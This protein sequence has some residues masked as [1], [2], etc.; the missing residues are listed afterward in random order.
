MKIFRLWGII[1][2]F[3]LGG[4]LAASW[5]FLAPNLIKNTIE[6]V[7]S[8]SLGAKVDIDKVEVALFPLRI[9]IARLQ[10]T[11]PDQP[12]SN[13]F[14]AEKINFALDTNALL[15]KK[16]LIE[17]LT[18]TGVQVGTKRTSSGEL[19]NGRKTEVVAEQ[20]AAIELP[21]LTESDIK[22]MVEQADL[23][24]VKRLQVLD[25]SQK[26]IQSE[27]KVA[28]DKKAYQDRI[29][30]LETEFEQLSKRAKD[31]KLNLIKDR[32]KW[33]KLKK[34][35]DKERD[36]ISELEKKIK[37]DKN[38]LQKQIASVRQGPKDDLKAIME[39][40]GLGN[41][42]AGLS[43]RFLSPEFTP[44]IEK[45]I[46]MTEGM[47][48][49]SSEKDEM[50]VYSTSKGKYVQFKDKQVFPDVLI[51][52]INLSGK[53]TE[54]E[55]SGLGSNL[56]YFPWLVGKPAKLNVDLTGKGSA[57]MSLK[58]DWKSSDKM[59]TDVNTLVSD[60][61]IEQMNLMQTDQGDWI[62][63]SGM[64][65]AKMKGQLTLQEID[66]KLSVK[67]KKPNIIAPENLSGWQQ[68]LADSLN[69]QKQITIDIAAKGSLD[70]P[71]ITVKS[72]LE[73]LF[74]AAIGKKLKQQAEKLKGK[75][76]SAISDKV[77]DLSSLDGITGDFEQW[78]EQLEGN[79]ELL[80]KLR[81]GI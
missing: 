59:H 50:P 4:G 80:E 53:D 22:K 76:S 18:L 67:L 52:K 1:V 54:W 32:K 28:L 26:Q 11:D 72:S 44:W 36:N 35:I 63:N 5:Y 79:D 29:S 71:K 78:S 46:A 33:K 64:L 39:K 62:I 58:S 60:W 70:D 74:T 9:E 30:K 24:T 81:K 16:V 40:T 12:M 15:W 21:E 51:K 48:D 7:G 10:A 73:K 19:A 6:E 42:I 77:G 56:G 25:K 55:I 23:I 65:D 68:A 31:N 61:S 34:S 69:Q 57:S 14:E 37:S 38:E 20:V 43:D 3:V 2:F 75:F 49:R 45:A 66:L 41:G 47:S 13:L 8:E 27:W 17:E